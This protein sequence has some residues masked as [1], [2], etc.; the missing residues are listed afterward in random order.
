MK[1]NNPKALCLGYALLGFSLCVETTWSAE[2][3]PKAIQSP[4]PAESPQVT[5]SPQPAESPQTTKSPQPIMSPQ[6]LTPQELE[7]HFQ[8]PE[9]QENPVARELASPSSSSEHP[10]R[11]SRTQALNRTR[12]VTQV[13]YSLDIDLSGSSDFYEAKA[14]LQ[15]DLKPK[16]KDTSHSLVVDF[17]GGQ[18]TA[19][20]VNDLNLS[21]F[22]R[23]ERFD[24]HHF[25]FNLNEL[26]PTGNRIEIT[27]S[28]LY[29][30]DGRGLHRF[31][32][33]VDGNPYLYTHFEPYD[34]HRMFPC[35]DQPDLK[36]TFELN[37]KAP[38]NWQVISN[39]LPRSQIEQDK[40][41][42]WV[43][44]K[45][46]P[47]STYL[48]ALH[49]GPF[50][51]WKANADAIP[52]RLFA[53]KSLEK[54]V[55]H[56]EWFK[57]TQQGLEYYS[58]QFGYPYPFGK[59]D[60]VLVPDF[61]AGAME[62]VGAVTFSESFIFRSRVTLD[63]KRRRA[64]T[65]LHEMAHMWF[66][67]LVTMKWWN[68]LW[69]N[70]SFATFMASKAVDQATEFKGTWQDFFSGIKQWAYWEDQMVTTHSIENPV[71]DTDVA[72]SIFDGITYGKGAA[73]LKQLQSFIGEDE[74]TEGLQRYFEKYAYKNTT[75]NDF[76]KKLSEAS[77]TDLGL[78]EKA[79]VQTPGINTLKAD[80]ECE[81][82]PK[83]D[84]ETIKKFDLI[85]TSTN[86]ELRAHYTLVGFFDSGK[87]HRQSKGVLEI[88]DSPIGV[89]YSGPKTSVQALIG[90]PCPTL[91]FPNY[92]DL[93]YVKVELDP[94]SLQKTLS[95]I[96][97]IQ[98]SLTRQ[99]LW[100]SLWEMVTDGK[101]RP[102]DYANAVLKNAERER[103]TLIL[104]KILQKFSQPSLHSASVL[105]FLEGAERLS[106]QKK[107]E[108]LAEQQ[109][110]KA[111]GGSDLQLIWYRAFINSAVSDAAIA[112]LNK[113][114]EGKAKLKAFNIDQERRWEILQTLARHRSANV[115]AL[116]QAELKADPTDFGQKSAIAAETAI[117]DL[118]VK[119]KWATLMM[120]EEPTLPVAKL[121]VAM[122]NFNLLGQEN[123][124]QSNTEFYFESLPKLAQRKKIDGAE[125][126]KDFAQSMYPALCDPKIIDRTTQLIEA[127]PELPAEVVKSLKI[128]RQEEERCT[129]ARLQSK[130]P[131]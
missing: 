15:F 69:L 30:H 128:H 28:H 52:L 126:L 74:F 63:Q 6:S 19:I 89:E 24:G 104:S 75:L 96:G 54:Y 45:S 1:K 8:Q 66:G 20:R 13:S 40:L 88:Q 58:S 114:F 77:G 131:S 56:A 26:K 57:I 120:Q 42:S 39:T 55:D 106:Y 3:K 59:Y 117:P 86:G 113:M 105:K 85:Q 21:D 10:S 18:V 68:G 127:H 29:S 72:E 70:E 16:A 93:D 31:Q 27:Y 33:P 32:D 14:I 81:L 51:V 48:F 50:A 110:A 124:S 92:N 64:D 71:A 108:T 22:N 98:D 130:Q 65:I 87:A 44:P 125:L 121:R 83:H 129:Q 34:A 100:H 111:P 97:V 82:K 11:L 80:W 116:I 4:Q 109:M 78:W 103:D 9:T 95:S 47:F 46:K 73:A 67:D 36:A 107:I 123:L 38:K 112:H 5:Q 12:L 76:F 61:N 90:K 7:A 37:V 122:K 115:E 84:H 2:D 43:F 102:Q 41:A 17:E 91:V 62:N 53:R 94:A 49:A 118:S 101:L 23:S 79:W 60:Q 99:M 35:F 119:K 25:Y